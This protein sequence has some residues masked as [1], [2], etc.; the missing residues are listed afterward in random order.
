[1]E[2]KMNRINIKEFE[3]D[4]ETVRLPASPGTTLKLCVSGPVEVNIYYIIERGFSARFVENGKLKTRIKRKEVLS[5]S[6]RWFSHPVEIGRR[7]EKINSEDFV[8]IARVEKKG[9]IIKTKEELC[10]CHYVWVGSHVGSTGT[11]GVA[12]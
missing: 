5:S 8:I 1:M 4:P 12:G 3:T 10:V 11:G 6:A 7:D 9:N 2:V